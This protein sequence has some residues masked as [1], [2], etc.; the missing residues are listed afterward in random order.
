M[1]APQDGIGTVEKDIAVEVLRQVE[2][3]ISVTP[4]ENAKVLRKIDWALLPILL[5]VYCLQSLDK[6]TLSY[7]AV[8]GLLDDTGL[9][10]EQFSWLGSIVYLAQLVMQPAVAFLLVKLPI[11][12][13]LATMVFL[14]GSMLCC[15]AAT[16]GFG[17]LLATR[18]FLG[19][20]EAAV[21]KSSFY[22][23]SIAY[24]FARTSNGTFNLIV[25][26]PSFIAIV[27]MWY[28]RSEQTYRNALWYS[29]L[30]IV[31]MVERPYSLCRN[32]L[33]E[34]DSLEAS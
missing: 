7:A 20:F 6:T 13:F 10:G 9:V 14:W 3:Q 30:G 4:D 31:N 34:H 32:K 8:F 17:G 11:G 21:G 27:Q 1:A 12:K 5:T 26:A 23:A 33:N 25:L 16:H 19:A 22:C 24:F 18:F 29:M 2:N 28:R 15:M